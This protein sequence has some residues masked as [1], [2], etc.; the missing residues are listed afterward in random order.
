MRIIELSYLSKMFTLLEPTFSDKLISNIYKPKIS[1]F[2][3]ELV[4]K[5]KTTFVFSFSC[6]V[7]FLFLFHRSFHKCE[8]LI[9]LH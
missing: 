8:E 1:S 9:K 6:P 2:T 4:S 7:D 5:Q 3:I